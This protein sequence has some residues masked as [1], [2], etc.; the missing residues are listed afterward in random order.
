[1]DRKDD[2][3]RR[4]LAGAL[5]AGSTVA[6]FASALA[7]EEIIVTA[8]RQEENIQEVPV[9]VSAFNAETLQQLNLR[10]I[11][12]VAR[13]T[14][15]FSFN[16]AFG[17]QPIS[18][19]PAIRGVTTI[20]N[21]TGNATAG[22]FFIDGVYLGGSPQSTELT[23]LER[24]EVIKGPQA[25]QFGRGTYA[26]AINFVTR[27]PDLEKL[28]G[29]VSLTGAEF[30][31]VEA[32]AWV[33]A[34]IIEDQLA[35]YVSAGYNETDGAFD[36]KFVLDGVAAGDKLGA[37]EDQN[38]T[39]KLLWAP[40]E[41]LE[42]TLKG[43]RQTTDDGH[44]AVYLQGADTLNCFK[45]RGGADSGIAPRNRGYFC[46]KAQPDWDNMTLATSLYGAA[47]AQAGARLDR[48]LATLTIN[49][50]DPE[51]DITFSSLTGY[52]EDTL[53]TGY[54]VSQAGYNA[55]PGTFFQIDKDEDQVITQEF[56]VTTSQ[57]ERL[58][59][60]AGVY[61]FHQDNEE[62]DNKRIVPAST[63]AAFVPPA[64]PSPNRPFNLLPGTNLVGFVAPSCVPTTANPNG[65]TVQRQPASVNLTDERIRNISVFGGI[66]YDITDRLTAG[67][68]ARYAEDNI[69]QNNIVNDGSGLSEPTSPNEAT[70]AAVTPRVS[71]RYRLTD[72]FNVY[73]NVAGGTRPGTFNA[74]AQGDF[75]QFRE[76][77][78][79]TMVAWEVG[80]KTQWFD[81]RLTANL[82]VYFNDIKDQQLTQNIEIN[83]Q[84][85]SL[86]LNSGKT[87]VWGVEL[88]SNWQITDNWNSGLTYAWTDSEITQR[89]ST[90]EADLRGWDGD[91]ATY[92]E[93]ADVSGRTSPRIPKNQFSLFTRYDLPFSWGGLYV[94]ADYTFESSRFAQED[95]LIETGDRNVVGARLGARYGNWDLSVWVRNLTDDDTPIDIQRY[96]DGR[97]GSLTGCTTVLPASTPA[98]SRAIRCS[99][100]SGTPRGF[101]LTP[102]LPRQY[103]ATLAYRFGGS[104]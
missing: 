104:R 51:S 10:N 102:Q 57:K 56:R 16:S 18:N 60:T 38:V 87:E 89:L 63:S 43:G 90:D 42:I 64:T 91:P 78:E 68:E 37:T 20:I 24:V 17:R 39:A 30:G 62:I 84:P 11:D 67:I 15:G 59:A 69:R 81:R 65:C 21:G 45:D 80:A 33:T 47:G 46:G 55:V 6:P 74:A 86:V 13:F 22:A 95:N 72:D 61:L 50:V 94:G 88:E 96:I 36:N 8:R 73:G 9:S 25:A 3:A 32:S 99:G 48:N 23:N 103:G 85:Q 93:F 58:R 97:A 35:F 77:D 79:E 41:G 4:L 82:A 101:T 14:P 5:L 100:A 26:G 31:T 71:L 53:R 44:Y 2:F 12:D 1:M 19:R 34:P 29:G 66:E 49:Y 92:A 40:V 83:G 52:T 54:D 75:A 76:V 7:A 28:D 70:F 27:K 98:P